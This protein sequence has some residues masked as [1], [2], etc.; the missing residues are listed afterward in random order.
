M[1]FFI[2]LV[3][4]YFYIITTMVFVNMVANNDCCSQRMLFATIVVM[5]IFLRLLFVFGS[6]FTI[7]VCLYY[8]FVI[9]TI[10]LYQYKDNATNKQR[11]IIFA[12][13]ILL[14]I[15]FFTYLLLIIGIYFPS[16]LIVKYGGVR[17]STGCS[18]GGDS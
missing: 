18:F 13:N 4:C 5:V 17:R 3:D 11:S 14:T 6:L 16:C 15:I 7:V 9:G 1:V 8:I 2:S 10:T 12:K